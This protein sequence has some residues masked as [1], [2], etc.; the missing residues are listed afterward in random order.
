MAA[1]IETPCIQ[2]CVIDPRSGF[3]I[4]CGRTGAEIA[5]WPELTVDQRRTVMATLPD[6]LAMMVSRKGRRH[7]GAAAG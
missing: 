6:R 2:V 5:A 1:G 3:C 4:G 7:A